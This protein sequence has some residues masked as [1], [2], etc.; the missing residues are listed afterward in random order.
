MVTECRESEF[1][2]FKANL[3]CETIGQEF[4]LENP[5]KTC[6]VVK[7]IKIRAR[8][9]GFI[10]CLMTVLIGSNTISFMLNIKLSLN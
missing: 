2:P 7:M 10:F 1:W 5:I 6:P 9:V 3:Q 4:T 8:N